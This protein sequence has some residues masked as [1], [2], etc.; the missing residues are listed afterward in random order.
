MYTGTVWGIT[1]IVLGFLLSL[2]ALQLVTTATAPGLVGQASRNLDR[3]SGRRLLLFFFCG[4]AVLGL[5]SGS[6]A[7]FSAGAPLVKLIMLP[8]VAL[9]ALAIAP[10]FAASSLYIGGRLPDPRDATSPWRQLVRGAT[11]L[12]LSWAVPFVGWFLIL[13]VTLAVGLAGVPLAV[14]QGDG[15]AEA[16]RAFLLRGAE[17]A[18]PVV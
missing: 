8:A 3:A 13:P 15:R 2:G 6:I 7:A 14:F 16:G 11:A 5:W 4:A 10:A 12:G 9:G 18:E 17:R 1:L